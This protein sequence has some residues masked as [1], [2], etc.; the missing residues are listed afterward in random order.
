MNDATL[1]TEPSLAQ[2]LGILLP[3]LLLAGGGLLVMLVDSFV[4]TLRKD[5]LYMLTVLLLLGAVLAQFFPPGG[6]SAGTLLGG[7]L[8]NEFYTRFFTYLFLGI[9]LLTAT[10]ATSAYDRDSRYRGEFYP[11]LLFAILGMM[12]LAAASDLLILYLG[13]EC[14]SLATYVLVG[15]QKGFIRSSEAGFKYLLL[16][17]FAS[18][19]LLFGIAL[20][21][22]FAGTTS[23]AGLA[24]K[25]GSGDAFLLSLGAGLV[26]I[27]F[28][29]KI[30]MVPFHMWTPDVYDGAPAYV[31]GF[32][33]TGIKAAAFAA[34]VRLVWLLL[35]AMA[36]FWFPL[37]VVL[38]VL[39]MTF[40][41]LVALAQSNIKRL[42]AYS[43][44]AHAGYLLLG[45]L[46][47]L[48]TGRGGAAS[49][50]VEE[51]AGAA[52]GG[53]LFYLIAYTIMNLGA[54]G[55]VSFL[56][57]SG[58]EEAFAISGYA[59]L[60]RRQPLAAASMAVFMLSLAG[61]P[62]TVGFMG[63][64]YIF[65]SVVRADLVP[66]AIWGV[67]NSLLSVY[68]YLRVVVVMYMQPAEE[69]A[70]DGRSWESSFAVSILA[71]LV[72]FLGVM[73]GALHRLSEVT[74]RLMA[75]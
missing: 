63:K 21:Y 49:L 53:I 26:L 5:H 52:G 59:G 65:E 69:A 31:S 23:F 58:E 28:G 2:Q 32:M 50:R 12:V 75:F 41:N 61:I 35:P 37:L 25:L 11:L 19:F 45:L 18:A 47:L 72:L 13:L 8:K 48:A 14:M 56:S 10:F 3:Y 55:V 66:L 43:S 24:A 36:D 34:L 73:P 17:G 42:L 4:K 67:V 38:A 6:I 51:V 40:G 29:F 33:A 46:A 54:F 64:L 30:A 7:M 15:G 1:A 39:T 22:G 57:R 62:P 20:L 74:F 16:G 44:I 9:A 70:Y 68:Y 60:A 71:F 27:G